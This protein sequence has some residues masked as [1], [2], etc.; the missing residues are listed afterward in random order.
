MFEED[1]ELVIHCAGLP[2]RCY[3]YVPEQGEEVPEDCLIK[4]TFDNFEIGA[5]YWGKLFNAHV[6]GG[7]VLYNRFFTIR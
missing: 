2:K 4:V 3:D 1:G 7:I 5:K 6:N